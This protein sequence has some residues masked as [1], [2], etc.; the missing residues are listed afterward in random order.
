MHFIENFLLLLNNDE[1]PTNTNDEKT[2]AIRANRGG[3]GGSSFVGNSKTLT[4]KSDS[5]LPFL[6]AG[7]EELSY[8]HYSPGAFY[9][10]HVD[11]F[12]APTLPIRTR[13]GERLS[14]KQRAVSFVL[15][16][17]GTHNK[18]EGIDSNSSG[19]NTLR[20]LD[21]DRDSG[22]LRVCGKKYDV[23]TGLPVVTVQQEQCFS[24]STSD[25]SQANKDNNSTS[26]SDKEEDHDKVFSDIPLLPRSLVLFYL[27]KILHAVTTA[28]R[29]RRRIV[30]YFHEFFMS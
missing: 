14:T 9:H 24:E 20:L 25:E 12:V 3:R 13:T 16:L 26:N 17:V 5:V 15:Y 21:M 2:A 6:P 10:K 29:S 22:A 28:T 19:N 8:L 27:A 11:I 30:G 18:G 1:P 7:M 23:L 4:E